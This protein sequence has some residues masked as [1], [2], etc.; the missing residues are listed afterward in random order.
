MLVREA[1]SPTKGF[2]AGDT[3]LHAAQRL[4]DL[5][6]GCLTICDD[7]HDL[8]GVIT[9]RDIML[10][11]ANGGNPASDLVSQL[12]HG[13]HV[14]TITAEHDLDQALMTMM[15]NGVRRLPVLSDEHLVGIIS[16]AD[17]ASEGIADARL[18]A[19]TPR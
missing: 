11:I 12:I 6:V 8:I 15:I 2:R 13:Q 3:V 17:L 9:D 18:D 19:A 1:M 16:A 10:S 5:N 4:R 7:T 14:V